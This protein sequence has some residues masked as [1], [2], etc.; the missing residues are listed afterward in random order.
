MAQT[1]RPK[2]PDDIHSA[3]SVD[4]RLP[5]ILTVEASGGPRIA[6]A[7]RAA[8]VEGLA[9]G[10]LVADARAKAPGLQTRSL[11]PEADRK[12]LHRLGLWAMRYTPAVALYRDDD[13]AD[14]LFID[15]AGASHLV[16]G[17]EALLEDVGRRLRHFSLRAR[18]AIADTS[19]AA[20]AL[21]RFHP[22]ANCILPPQ[23]EAG[24]ALAPLPLAALRLPE[25]LCQT[26]RRLG[27]TRIG[28]LIGKDRA[29]FASR[30]DALLLKRLDQALGQ[31]QEALAFLEPPSVYHRS[32]Q[33]L[34]PISSQAAVVRVAT[35]LMHDLVPA[36]ARDGLG[37]RTLLLRLFR[38]DGEIRTIRIGLAAATRD[39]AHVARLVEL[40][41]ERLGETID[42]GFGFETISLT[43]TLTER[44]GNQQASFALRTVGKASPDLDQSERRTVLID[45]LRQRLGAAQV[46]QIVPVALHDP[47]QAET[48][49][50]A[51]SEAPPWPCGDPAR[52]RPPLFLEPPEAV[53]IVTSGSDGLPTHFRWR[54]AGHVVAYLQGPERIVG[55]WWKLAVPALPTTSSIEDYLS[56][57]KDN[58]SH[59]GARLA[60]GESPKS[61]KHGD[62][63]PDHTP[64]KRP[65]LP[66]LLQRDY[67]IVETTMGQRFWLCRESVGR[68][69]H[70]QIW[71]MRGIFA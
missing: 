63:E 15:I 19:G 48:L 68:T 17:E 13:H 10:G 50:A 22:K 6:A 21:S 9:A 52:P 71:F 39:P 46:Q 3:V 66:A 16:G 57:K 8:E 61:R 70:Q 59:T 14:G 69:L 55:E 25:D 33:L 5:F 45:A 56:K 53:Q 11:D 58:T 28:D 4:N 12:A 38:V 20:W 2:S 34:D 31:R 65:P 1:Q 32:R 29:P 40:D 54:G 36:L 27:F 47:A 43:A 7:N 64:A 24:E 67:F 23:E 30:F 42:A 35:R 44:I 49:L 51:G 62:F 60:P 26:L 18:L 37:A 41:L